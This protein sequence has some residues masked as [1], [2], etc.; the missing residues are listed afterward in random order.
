M[1]FTFKAVIYKVGINPCVDVP[2]KISSKLQA[3]RGY[4][5]VLGKINGHPF[6]QHLVP[7]KAGLYR[8]YVNIP[9]MKG[10][11]VK[12]GDTAKFEIE[13]GDLEP[14]KVVMTT[15]LKSR[16]K[17]EDLLSEFNKL[18]P[19]RQKEINRYINSLKTDDARDRNIEK[20]VKMLKR[21]EP[22]CGNW[23]A[24][25]NSLHRRSFAGSV[26]VCRCMCRCMEFSPTTIPRCNDSRI[27]LQER[28]PCSG[29]ICV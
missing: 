12:F 20:V 14:K 29:D 2:E 9:M 1:D 5:P 10:A 27:W 11:E 24:G 16:L 8:L 13:Q 18:I 19:S 22:Q 23:T 25:K 21:N 3:R 17:K 28:T 26:V 15:S 4:I 7:V 6:Q